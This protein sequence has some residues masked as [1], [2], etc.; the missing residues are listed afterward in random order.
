MFKINEKTKFYIVLFFCI[1]S[2][3]MCLGYFNNSLVLLDDMTF[4]LNRISDLKDSL[5]NG[6]FFATISDKTLSGYGYANSFFYP[7][8]FLYVPAFLNLIGVN[9]ITSYK[10]FMYIITLLTMIVAYISANNIFIL[11]QK[12]TDNSIK[13]GIIFSLLYTAFPYRLI[14]VFYRGAIG[15]ILS[16]IF[17]PLV[18]WGVYEI[19]K[20]EDKARWQ[21]LAIGMTGVVYSHVL[22]LFLFSLMVLTICLF[23][24][25][26]LLNKQVFIKFLKAMFLTFGL[27][28]YFLL[29]FIEQYLSQG[30]YFQVKNFLGTP[31]ENL[32]K[33]L[34]HSNQILWFILNTIFIVSIFLMNKYYLFKKKNLDRDMIYLIEISIYLFIMTTNIFPWGIVEKLPF[35]A[36][37]QFTWRLF[38]ILSLFFVLGLS[39]A[40]YFSF[41]NVKNSSIHLAM[42]LSTLF[43]FLLGY[44]PND[45]EIVV[46]KDYDNE[47]TSIGYA[48]Y[49]PDTFNIEYYQNKGFNITAIDGEI[50]SSNIH[51]ENGSFIGEFEVE[52]ENTILELP[53]TYYKGYKILLNE[54]EIC[55]EKSNKGLIQI[56]TKTQVRGDITVKYNY[57]L[58]QYLGLTISFINLLIL[59]KSHKKNENK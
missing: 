46:N 19:F 42:T 50:K 38:L 57:L 21:I 4:H 17:L 5:R 56:N 31:S 20:R 51:K 6:Y 52:S 32:F 9:L 36:Q 8:L 7:D 33:I 48:E 16:S 13:F 43:I 18:F 26:K 10:I 15:E 25:R 54:E 14:N 11:N 29:P 44:S 49:L 39:R 47:F 12:T 41:N 34:N 59:I 23:N 45:G 28:A 27:S 30:Y 37:I 24:Y 58:M 35:I 22:S 3:I 55:Y 53:I 40:I 2:L 1:S